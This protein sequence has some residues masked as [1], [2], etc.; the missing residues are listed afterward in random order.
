M[1]MLDKRNVTTLMDLYELTMSNGYFKYGFTNKTAVFDVFFRNNP[2]EGGY[3]IFVGLKEIVDYILSFHFDKEDI[4]Y[5]RSLNLFNEEFL[6]YLSNF[7]FKGDVYSFPEGSVIYP[8]TPI[9]TVVAPL[10]DAQMIETGILTYFNHESLIATKTNR[11]VISSKGR[12]V[13]DFGAR[14]AHGIDA[15]LYGAKS[16][17]I[18]GAAS[19]ATV[20]A[21][22]KFKIPLSGTMAHSWIMSFENEYDAFLAYAKLYPSSPIF[23]IDTYNV[24]H[25]GLMNAIK[26]NKEYLIPNGYRLK[27]VRL[28]SGDLSY[29]SKKCRK[30]LDD[31]GMEDC[32]ICATNSLDEYKIQSLLQ[33]EAP[34]DLFG[35]GENLITSKSN[36]VF[37][38]VYKLVAI[39]NQNE[40]EFTA[41]IKVSETVEKITNPGFKDV[42]RVY[43]KENNKCI[44][45]FITIHNEE[46]NQNEVKFIDP[47]K[48]WKSLSFKNCSFKKMNN[49]IIKNGKLVYE[50]PSIDDIRKYVRNQIDNELREEEKRFIMPHIHYVDYSVSFYNLKMKL[51]EE[52]K[53]NG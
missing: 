50:I 23:L 52:H 11:I 36:P 5:L 29:L 14:R 34:I 4:D 42:Y 38:G 17:Y 48:P 41:K 33:Q 30:I 51:I 6:T 1:I 21:G 40:Q 8:S 39:K 9:I 27:A 10:I 7:K 43:D 31:N 53:Y 16:A 2:D 15:A 25:S 37:G 13:S 49:L 28:D 19:T 35:V 12:S 3:S 47:N 24:I 46:I 45:D 20:M 26:V 32:L 22:L 18:A 44:A